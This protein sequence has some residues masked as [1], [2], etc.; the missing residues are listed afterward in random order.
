MHMS[1]LWSRAL[2]GLLVI[3]MSAAIAVADP[4]PVAVLVLDAGNTNGALNL[5]GEDRLTVHKGD[6]VVNS[7]HAAAVFNANSQIEVKDGGFRVCGGMSP[8]G[9]ATCAPD[10]ETGAGA[11]QDPYAKTAWPQPEQ[12]VS[13]QKLF[14]SGDKEETLSPGYYMGGLS[15]TGQGLR[16]HL[17]PGLYVFT[18]GDL[19]VSDA[20]VDGQG[21]TI[22]MSGNAPGKLLFANNSQ[23]TLSAPKD[24]PLQDLVLVSA[25]AL[26]G[27]D[28]DIGFNGGKAD[29]DGVIYAPRGRVGAYFKS[30]VVTGGIVGFALMLNTGATIDAL[31]ERKPPPEQ[32]N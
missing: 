5:G 32:P 17:E 14:L 7:A 21:V 25:R 16:V 27:Y 28:T 13:R 6:L 2:P 11:G 19:F 30:Q 8:I 26:Q 29:L 12:V 24:G 22:L 4:L 20:Q 18:D 1:P 15:C 10:P 23:V 9:T 3:L 31:G